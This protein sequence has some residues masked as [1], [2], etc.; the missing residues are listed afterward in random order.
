VNFFL[1]NSSTFRDRR[2]TA[3]NALKGL[4]SIQFASARL[5]T[6]GSPNSFIFAAPVGG[7]QTS[8]AR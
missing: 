2:L 1:N 5:L 7:L 3:I 8:Q 4:G 6:S